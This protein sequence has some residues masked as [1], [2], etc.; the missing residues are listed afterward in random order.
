MGLSR[1]SRPWCR[2]T[3][4]P[5]INHLASPRELY[6]IHRSID[7]A[8]RCLSSQPSSHHI[9]L[10]R[11][12]FHQLGT[13][14]PSQRVHRFPVGEMADQSGSARFQSFFESAWQDYGRNT[15][16]PLVQHPLAV[17]L[18]SCQS[19][20]DI[21]TLL[22]RQVQAFSDLKERDRMMKA[23]KTIVSILVPLSDV[24][25]V[26]EAVGVVRHEVM[27]GL[28]YTSEFFISDIIPTCESNTSKSCY[29]TG[30]MCRSFIHM[31]ISL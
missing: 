30:C 10:S 31:S 24:T 21:T 9:P 13:N 28:F 12:H 20:D 14:T 2:L 27:D 11:Y 1:A 26:A 23:I 16:V 25:S 3:L 8:V 22:Q 4:T 19:V 15:G 5:P 17:D 18:Q 29:T 7:N 6:I